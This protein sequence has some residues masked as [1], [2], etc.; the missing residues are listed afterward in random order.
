M[1][2][3]TDRIEKKSLLRAPRAR[4]WRALTD[5]VELGTWFGAKLPP[6][7]MK[8]GGR[9]RGPLTHPGYE[10]VTLDI[11]IERIEPERLFSW[12]WHPNAVDP[13][14]DYSKDPTTL[15]VFTLDEVAGGTMLTVVESG[16]DQVPAADRQ[17]ALRSNDQGWTA[18]MKNVERHVG[19]A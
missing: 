13:Q 17:T 14:R 18:Q 8:P 4:V 7:E 12:R 3:E 15:V 10:H 16:F 6:G 11:T 5:P 2:S 1:S 19:A 9:V